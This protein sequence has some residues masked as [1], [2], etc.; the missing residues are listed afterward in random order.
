MLWSADAGGVKIVD[1]DRAAAR[2]SW[3]E[4]V[5]STLDA[6]L[7]AL[8]MVPWRLDRLWRLRL[9]VRRVDVAQFGWLLDLPL[10]QRDG[11]RFQVTPRQVLDAPARFGD[12]LRRVLAA[13]LAF[14]IHVVAHRGR[15]VILDG[16]HRLARAMIEG[17]R[18]IDAMVLSPADLQG[19]C[20]TDRSASAGAD[21]GEN[22]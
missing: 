7:A 8:P 1:G 21:G 4:L 10:W 9:P 22:G 11:R 16:Y 18:E 5:A 15:L 6:V 17:R 12:H 14:P 2:M 20:R 3:D 19:I 13:D